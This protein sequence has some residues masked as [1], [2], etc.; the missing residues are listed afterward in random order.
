MYPVLFRLGE[1]EVTSFGVMVAVGAL[2][3]LWLFRRELRWSGLSESVTDAAL[4]GVLGGLAGAKLLWTIENAGQEPLSDLLFARGGLS[5]YGGLVGGVG[6]GIALILAK[7][8]PLVP[9]LAAAT[10]ALAV[11]HLIGRIGC[12]LVGDDY[13][14]PTALPWGVAFPQGLPPTTVPVHPTQLYEAAFLG[15]LAWMLVRWRRRRG[16]PDHVVL[17]RYL[18]LAGAGRF[19]IEFLRVNERVALG[20]TVAQIFSLALV[21]A[22]LALTMARHPGPQSRKGRA[23]RSAAP[24]ARSGGCNVAA[25]DASYQKRTHSRRPDRW[26]KMSCVECRSIRQKQPEPASTTARRTTSV[27]KA[28]KPNST[29]IRVSTRSRSRAAVP[30]TTAAE[31]PQAGPL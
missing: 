28:A 26:K 9:T 20:L 2:V 6:T 4:W 12:F 16:V 31:T 10:P 21:A 22:G 18:L 3:G 11:G 13:G 29:R 27:R 19:A 24:A 7:R 15:W 17:G 23:G 30:A 14:R 1:F 8:H 5:W 25:S